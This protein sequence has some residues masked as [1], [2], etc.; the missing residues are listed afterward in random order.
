[1]QVLKHSFEADSAKSLKSSAEAVTLV[2]APQF[3]LRIARSAS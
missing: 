1:V 2:Q 3:S